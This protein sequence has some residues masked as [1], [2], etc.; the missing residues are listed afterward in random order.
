ML[1]VCIMGQVWG[2]KVK[3]DTTFYDI[4]EDGAP[5]EVA[6]DHAEMLLQNQ[7]KWRDPSQPI[8]PNKHNQAPNL[9][10]ILREKATGRILSDAETVQVLQKSQPVPEPA[11]TEPE[12]PPAAT[13]P[14]EAKDEDT[15]PEVSLSM[16]KSDLVAVA[17]E[18]S[19]AGHK[20][21]TEGSKADILE[22]IED[23]YESM[24]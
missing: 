5:F 16:R 23:A 20:V 15:W 18:L 9:S 10:P 11:A 3:V 14:E 12:P 13:E 24:S 7:R 8:T 19:A 17:E 21:S 22:S 1:V 6:D 4:P 2:Q